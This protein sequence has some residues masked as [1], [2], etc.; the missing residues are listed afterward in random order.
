MLQAV[1]G[2]TLTHTGRVDFSDNT[3]VIRWANA[4]QHNLIT[5][6]GCYK[7]MFNFNNGHFYLL[8]LH[9]YNIIS[10]FNSLNHRMM[11]IS[12]RRRKTVFRT[13]GHSAT[14]SSSATKSYLWLSHGTPPNALLTGE[15][16]AARLGPKAQFGAAPWIATQGLAMTR[17]WGRQSLSQAGLGP[18]AIVLSIIFLY[19]K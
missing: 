6:F 15:Y 3:V 7:N 14:Q 11:T 9:C 5:P 8:F 18:K 1:S 12:T 2:W 16:R 19:G 17:V 4:R 10:A 13:R